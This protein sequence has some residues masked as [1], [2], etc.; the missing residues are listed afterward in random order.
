MENLSPENLGVIPSRIVA[1][2][3]LWVAAAN[4]TQDSEDIIIDD[5]TPAGGYTLAYQ[6][7]APTP[8]SV[9]AV[10]NSGNTGWT[11]EVTGAQTLAWGA[12]R[13]PYV[14]IATIVVSAGPPEVTRTFPVDQGVI[15]VDA[16]PM[17]VS[18]WAAVVASCDAAIATYAANPNGSLS[19]E[20]M[21][22]SYRSLS[23][24]TDLRDYATYRLQQDTASRPR[25]IIRTRFT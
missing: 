12:G 22:V 20:G 9:A 15:L 1:G 8:L 2:A 7:A 11:L 14:G 13:I 16:S 6:F 25:R 10:A 19:I 4:T 3:S 21:S 24:L 5:Y 18:A 23:Q 17:R